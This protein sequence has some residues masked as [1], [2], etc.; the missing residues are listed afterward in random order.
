MIKNKANNEITTIIGNFN[1]KI[2]SAKDGK[3]VGPF[4]MKERND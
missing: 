1:A 3:H 2:G 4:E